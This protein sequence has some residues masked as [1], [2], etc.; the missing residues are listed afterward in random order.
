MAWMPTTFTTRYNRRHRRVGHLFQGRYRAEI[1][2]T[3][4]YATLLMIYIHLNPIRRKFK[5]KVEYTEGLRELASFGWSGHTDLLR[6]RKEALLTLDTAWHHYW[7]KTPAG[8]AQGY[9]KP[10]VGH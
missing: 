8:V 6:Q 1:V 7:A 4:A 9:R 3:D 5:G 10:V 2:D